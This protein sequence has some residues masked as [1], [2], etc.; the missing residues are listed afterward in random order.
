MLVDYIYTKKTG[1]SKPPNVFQILSYLIFSYL[2]F[3][4]YGIIEFYFNSIW[5]VIIIIQNIFIYY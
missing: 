2:M 4:F 3:L 5:K 1:F